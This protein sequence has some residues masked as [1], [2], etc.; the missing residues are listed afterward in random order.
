M[1]KTKATQ[2]TGIKAEALR[3]LVNQECIEIADLYRIHRT[4]KTTWT[5]SLMIGEGGKDNSLIWTGPLDEVLEAVLERTE[6]TA[7]RKTVS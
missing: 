1:T 4:K 5:L 7:P 2:P 3:L 6:P